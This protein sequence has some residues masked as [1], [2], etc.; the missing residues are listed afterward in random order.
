MRAPIVEHIA[1]TILREDPRRAILEDGVICLMC[2]RT[3]RHLTNTHL[4][5]HGLT[6]GEYKDSFGYNSRRPLMAMAVRR[7][8]SG[9]ALR[10]GLADMI[11]QRPIVANPALRARG[12]VRARTLEEEL[13]RRENRHSDCQL[14]PRDATGRFLCAD[15]LAD[16][17]S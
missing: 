15:A 12:R 1:L 13:T 16:A 8:H 3:L 9:N 14:P 11:R 17:V 2:G 6:S 10:R 7:L 4:A 5:H